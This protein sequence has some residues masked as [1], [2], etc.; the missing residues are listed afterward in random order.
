MGSSSKE[1][2][3]GGTSTNFRGNSRDP[4]LKPSQSSKAISGNL[5]GLGSAGNN[6]GSKIDKDNFDLN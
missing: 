2:I 3:L 4:E 1:V 6:E 5:N